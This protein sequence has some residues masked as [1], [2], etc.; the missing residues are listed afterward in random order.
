LKKILIIQIAFGIV[1]TAFLGLV[2]LKYISYFHQKIDVAE[3][4][5]VV[6]KNEPVSKLIRE[7]GKKGVI[8]NPSWLW[9]YYKV[10]KAKIQAG[11]YRFSG[12][13]SPLDV[14]K[15]LKEGKVETISLTFPEGITAQEVIRKL[16]ENKVIE[17]AAIG[18]EIYPFLEGYL[19]PDTYQFKIGEGA[20]KAIT[21]MI[22]RFQ[23]KMKRFGFTDKQLRENLIIA[24]LIE[25][26]SVSDGA[27]VSEV[28]HNRLKLNMPLGLDSA[29]EYAVGRTRLKRS[30]FYLDTPY[31]LYKRKGLPPTPICNP[32]LKAIEYSNDAP[33][34]N[35]LYFLSYNGSTFFFTNYRKEKEWIR[36]R[37][38]GN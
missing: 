4:S 3:V 30:D 27:K 6:K 37:N 28:I 17:K 8:R 7:L 25:K 18:K 16:E 21:K 10:T 14:V 26:E 34:G 29:L 12:K 2:L 32:S 23:Q 5:V 15:K 22:V 19:F 38:R 1:I 35:L 24:S 9:Y 33:S 13:I 31:N 36:T 11:V 20:K